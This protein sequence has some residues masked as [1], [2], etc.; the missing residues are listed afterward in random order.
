MNCKEIIQKYLKE[1]GYDGLINADL[2][3]G[4]GIDDFEPCGDLNTVDCKAAYWHECKK[5]KTF[6]NCDLNDSCAT[7]CGCFKEE[8]QN[9]Q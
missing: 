8:K 3:C 2:E 9:V 7:E 4:C 1:N 5:C 6:P